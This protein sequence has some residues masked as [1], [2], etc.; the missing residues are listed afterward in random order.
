MSILGAD[1]LSLMPRP[2][3][4]SGPTPSVLHAPIQMRL[5][6]LDGALFDQKDEGRGGEPAE[7]GQLDRGGCAQAGDRH[8]EDEG[9]EDGGHE[10]L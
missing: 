1:T 2:C 4:S 3:Y 9:P 7:Q 6:R 8:Q 5:W 10:G